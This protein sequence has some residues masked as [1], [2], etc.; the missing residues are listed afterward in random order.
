MLPRVQEYS[1]VY[2]ILIAMPEENTT[3][4]AFLVQMQQNKELLDKIYISTEKTRKMFFWTLIIS[5]V[6]VILP[7][8]GLA[9]AIPFFL[10][11]YVLP[12]TGQQLGL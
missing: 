11:S 7:L 3:Q 10:H 2:A 5:L 12:L 4:Q 9:F 6:T 8:I 1:L